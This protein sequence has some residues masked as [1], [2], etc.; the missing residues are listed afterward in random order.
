MTILAAR[1]PAPSSAPV[2]YCFFAAFPG[3]F[4]AG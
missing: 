4:I 3:S 2:N 1:R